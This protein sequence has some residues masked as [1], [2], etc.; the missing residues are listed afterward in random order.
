MADGQ[1]MGLLLA[2]TQATIAPYGSPL[3]LLLA[4]TRPTSVNTPTA[5]IYVAKARSNVYHA[6][7]RDRVY[8]A[9]D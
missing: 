7:A 1:P 3:G 9:E 8:E 2:I 5:R 6:P 4:I